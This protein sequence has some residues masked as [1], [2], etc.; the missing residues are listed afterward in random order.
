MIGE[1][2]ACQFTTGTTF[3]GISGQADGGACYVWTYGIFQNQPSGLGDGSTASTGFP[4][5]NKFW[6]DNQLS[7]HGNNACVRLK[8]WQDWTDSTSPLVVPG[9]VYVTPANGLSGASQRVVVVIEFDEPM[10]GSSITSSTFTLKL[11]GTAVPGT[12]AYNPT[13]WT[14]TFT[15]AGT[16]ASYSSYTAQLTTAVQNAQGVALPNPITWSFTTAAGRS[17]S[18]MAWFPGLSKST[19]R[20]F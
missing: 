15:P 8:A 12:V 5:T 11:G 9:D 7:N 14:A 17:A 2:F 1:M 13:T 19:A 16:L 20:R 18:A 4:I 10:L 6:T 3:Y